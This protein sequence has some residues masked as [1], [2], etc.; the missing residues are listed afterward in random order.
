MTRFYADELGE[1]LKKMLACE[2]MLIFAV[3]KA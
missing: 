2:R 1:L 3:M